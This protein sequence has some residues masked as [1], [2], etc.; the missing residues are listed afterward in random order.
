MQAKE[1]TCRIIETTWITP[2]VMSVKFEPLRKFAFEA[3]Q[4]ISIVVPKAK[5][6]GT[7]KRCY[8]LASSP[9]EARETGIYELC[10]KFAEGGAGTTYLASLKKGD[11]FRVYGSYGHLKFRLPKAGRSVCFISTGTGLAPFRSIIM[12]DN[13]QAH[14]PDHTLCLV[15]VRTE[16]EIIYQQELEKAGANTVYAVSQ[17]TENFA[18]FRGRVTDYLKSLPKNTNWH[19]TD[20]Y[21]CGNGPMVEE[22]AMLLQGAFGVAASAIHK[23]S[24]SAHKA[25]KLE[26]EHHNKYKAHSK[27]ATESEPRLMQMALANLKQAA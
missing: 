18:G 10:V 16:D 19:T 15:G 3:G 13:F 7:V 6:G 11:T 4:F 8:S 26:I 5:G 25:G 23:E 22:V 1:Y 17:P 24:F 27:A 2:T 14:R 20:F 9:D 12:S 21:L